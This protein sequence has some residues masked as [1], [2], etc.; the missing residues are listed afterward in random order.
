MLESPTELPPEE[1]LEF[2]PWV[3]MVAWGA[4]GLSCLS[5]AYYAFYN[6]GYASG[7]RDATAQ[8]EG[9][10]TD[11]LQV[12]ALQ[13]AAAA[14]RE[15]KEAPQTAEGAAV[16]S[17]PSNEALLQMA[18]RR[19]ELFA[20]V[21]N[22]ALRREALGL[23]LSALIDRDLLGSAEDLL[24]EVMPP[25][26]PESPVWARRMLQAARWLARHSRWEQAKAYM[27]CVEDAQASADGLEAALR[28]HVEIIGLA[29]LPREALCA[30]LA[31][32]VEKAAGAHPMLGAELQVYLGKLYREQ[33]DDTRA[34]AHFHAALTAMDARRQEGG[35][36]PRVCYGV[37]LYETGERKKAEEWL[38]AGLAD[39]N[40]ADSTDMRAIALR[41]LAT[42]CLEAGRPM[43]ALRYL[44]RAEGEATG[45]I[46]KN[47]SFWLCLGD[48]RA[49][50][51]YSMHEYEESLAGFRQV[52]AAAGE[53][54]E[55]L[56]AQP[57]EGVARCCLSLG[58]AQ[59]AIRAAADCISLR[60]RLW[61][62]D[63]VSLGRV[64][65]LLGQ[66]YDQG[67]Q[68]LSAAEAYGR[69]AA[70]L[71]ADHGGRLMA[72]SGQAYALTQAQRWQEA[73]Q[74]WELL[75]PLLP[76]EDEARIEHAKERLAACRQKAEAAHHTD[77][78][79]PEPKN[80]TENRRRSRR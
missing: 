44:H 22:P 55:S 2:K 45:R 62:G 6:W 20:G 71:P 65:I 48:Q 69:A 11:I 35:A 56:R 26:K 77:S 58:Q 49:W 54:H 9:C 51:L 42:L 63:K 75:L 80:E 33:G 70:V 60:E 19:A 74:A 27:Q 25:A 39:N 76:Q 31:S 38:M 67:G 13:D 37:A 18:H 73:A 78:D 57:L 50:A 68:V 52:L 79:T 28:E 12:V 41:H 1:N 15:E 36:L 61:S 5:L 8:A 46:P 14:D 30:E 40:P 16:Q 43:E 66:A 59:E 23:L 7:A 32:L 72:L 64:Y 4:A 3:K 34:D 24:A 47:S 10:L 29:G 53:E 21:A 17:S